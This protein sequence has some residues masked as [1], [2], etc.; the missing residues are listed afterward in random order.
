LTIKVKG[1]FHLVLLFAG[2]RFSS[3]LYLGVLPMPW[4]ER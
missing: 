3:F 1:S 4:V 2:R